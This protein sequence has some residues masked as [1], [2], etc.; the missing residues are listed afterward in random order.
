MPDNTDL[1]PSAPASASASASTPPAHRR[2]TDRL[3]D[4]RLWFWLLVVALVAVRFRH[5][6]EIIAGPHSG[7]QCDTA[8]YALDFY[9][10]GIDLL[11]PSVC[12]LGAHKTL[13]LEFPLPEAVMAL[14]YH[15]VG[16]RLLVARLLT[17]AA[18]L[19]SAFYLYKLIA[20]MRSPRTAKLATLLYLAA[21]LSLVY[22]RAVHVDFWA[23]LY[24]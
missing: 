22:S 17:L 4:G 19:G 24:A 8:F 16:P 5:M 21:P 6:G 11:H 1:D 3:L 13:A 23:V 20:Y 12:W 9:R 15:V 18:Y 10:N 14:A 7:R 2:L